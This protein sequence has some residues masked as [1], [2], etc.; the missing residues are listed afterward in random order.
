MKISELQS[1]DVVNVADGKRLGTVGDLEIHPRTGKIEALIVP[2]EGKILGF[3]R[4]A[5][6][7]IQWG[8]IV[9]I[10][11]DVILVRKQELLQEEA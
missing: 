3:K 10:G 1:K 11:A 8:Q 9:K 6:T 7:I 2:G 5:E 4:E